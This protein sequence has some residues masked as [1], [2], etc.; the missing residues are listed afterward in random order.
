MAGLVGAALALFVALVVLYPF[1]RSRF[2]REESATPKPPQDG[3]LE[4]DGIFSAIEELERQHRSGELLEADF[5]EQRSG[6]R[7][8]AALLLR[9]QEERQQ[10]ADQALEQEVRRARGVAEPPSA[11]GA[12]S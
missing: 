7:Q 10:K 3:Q 6:Y 8:Q 1:V 2:W 12:V 5:Q 4:L 9:E 11:D